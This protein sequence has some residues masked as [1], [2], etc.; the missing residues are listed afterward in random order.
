MSRKGKQGDRDVYMEGGGGRVQGQEKEQRRATA[1]VA[2]APWEHCLLD[3]GAQQPRH[4][5]IDRFSFV[6]HVRF[7]FTAVVCRTSCSAAASACSPASSSLCGRLRGHPCGRQNCPGFAQ[8]LLW[9]AIVSLGQPAR[10]PAPPR[11]SVDFAVTYFPLPWYVRYVPPTLLDKH[12][13]AARCVPRN[14]IVTELLP[15]K[16]PSPACFCPPAG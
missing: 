1:Q 3:A 14:P 2:G 7:T 12:L 4:H 15:A 13:Q 8:R 16:N 10:C 5:L 9:P 6:L 11:R